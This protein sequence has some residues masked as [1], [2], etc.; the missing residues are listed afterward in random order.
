MILQQTYEP[1]PLGPLGSAA[2]AVSLPNGPNG[3]SFYTF[4]CASLAVDFDASDH[5]FEFLPT[6]PQG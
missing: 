5:D 3:L 4:F 2:C 1:R 6:A